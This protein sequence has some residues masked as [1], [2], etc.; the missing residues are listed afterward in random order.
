MLRIRQLDGGLPLFFFQYLVQAG[1][2]FVVPL[3]LS[4][5]L[6]LSAVETGVRLLPLSFALLIAAVGVPKAVARRRRRGGSRIGLLLPRARD[7]VLAAAID[8]D[9]GAT[10]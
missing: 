7:V 3:F 10:S 2:F 1:L 6:G 4:V 5:V 9:A 8:A